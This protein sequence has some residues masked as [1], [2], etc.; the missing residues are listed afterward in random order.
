MRW[1]LITALGSLVDPLVNKNFTTVSGPVACMAASTSG[2]AGVASRSDRAVRCA[3]LQPSVWVSTTSTSGASTASMEA[4]YCAQL[5]ANTSP[6]VR[7]CMT[8]RSLS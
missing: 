6:G 7:V 1:V 3:R 8:W 5:G 2:R 4:P